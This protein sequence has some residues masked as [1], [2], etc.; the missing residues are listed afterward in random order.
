MRNNFKV[1]LVNDILSTFLL[2]LPKKYRLFHKH[3]YRYGCQLHV[4][5]TKTR[6]YNFFVCLSVC[7]FVQANLYDAT[8]E[9]ILTGLLREGIVGTL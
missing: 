3:N 5:K 2:S 8:A 4:N 9:L 6:V 1:L 7:L